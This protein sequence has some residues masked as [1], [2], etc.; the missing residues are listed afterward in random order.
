MSS[1]KPIGKALVGHTDGA[2]CVTI[3]NDGRFIA[4]GSQDTTV[5]IWDVESGNLMAKSLIHGEIVKAVYVSAD[6]QRIILV[7]CVDKVYLRN[8]STGKIL[9]SATKGLDSACLLWKA[10]NGWNDGDEAGAQSCNEKPRI[11]VAGQEIS[12]C[13]P[14]EDK[15]DENLFEKVGQFDAEVKDWAVD[16]TGNLWV[17][18]L[19][20][21]LSGLIMVVQSSRA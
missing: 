13:D 6:N 16:V 7:D 21:D 1:G 17:G 11:T 3:S 15:K 12:L 2:L 9:E 4:S 18:L 14:T 8:T 19:G 5:R 10:R 20:V